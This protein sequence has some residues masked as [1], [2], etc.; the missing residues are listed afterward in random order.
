MSGQGPRGIARSR[1][2]QTGLFKKEGCD[3]NRREAAHVSESECP[4]RSTTG[5][6]RLPRLLGQRY[7]GVPSSSHRVALQEIRTVPN[8]HHLDQ[9]PD[10]KDTD[11]LLMFR[12]G[13]MP[14]ALRRHPLTRIA[15]RAIDVDVE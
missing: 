5:Q 15:N 3:N 4:V 2:C 10:R 8:R 13:Q 11:D 9:I 7:V 1:V 12:N 6:G 14:D